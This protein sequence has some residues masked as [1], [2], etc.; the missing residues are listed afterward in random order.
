MKNKSLEQRAHDQ[1]QA[2]L[3]LSKKQW[4]AGQEDLVHS[5]TLATETVSNTLSVERCSVWIYKNNKSEIESIDLYESCKN[6]HS[7]GLILCSSHYPNY[8]KALL[9]ERVISAD[10]ANTDKNTFEFSNNYLKP[11]GINSMLDAPIRLSGNTIGVFCCEHI[12]KKRH[13]EIDE[14]NFVASVADFC[15]IS[16][17]LSEHKKTSDELRSHKDKLESIVEDRTRELTDKNLE[18]EAFSYSISHDLRAPLRHISGYLNVI[19][20]DFSETIDKRGCECI[21]KAM[22]SLEKMNCMIDSMLQLSRISTQ[23]TNKEKLNLS[24]MMLEISEQLKDK[25]QVVKIKINNTPDTLGDIGLLRI[26]LTNLFE[27][28]LKYSQKTEDPFIEFGSTKENEKIVYFVRDNGSGFDMQY[29]NKL[30][31]PFQRLHSEAEFEGT[32]IGLSTVQRV[33]NKHNGNIRA[34]GEVGKGCTFFFDLGNE[35]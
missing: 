7:S 9:E 20:E 11:L 2:L 27:N 25:D 30:F 28:S 24:D 4:L 17:E 6:Q 10:D 18:L 15:S 19:K 32:G 21:G 26:A 29:A 31:A 33:I 22:K 23:E 5:L 13:W 8:F 1:Q 35:N 3:L 12:G 16:F 14:M 34:I